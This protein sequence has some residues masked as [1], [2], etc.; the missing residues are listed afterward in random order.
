M[1]EFQEGNFI[2]LAND[3]D[4]SQ[5]QYFI[6]KRDANNKAVLASAAT[7]DIEGVLNNAPKAKWGADVAVI[8][9]NGTFKVVAG[10]NITKGDKLTSD[11]NGKAVTAA[12]TTAGAQPTKHVFGVALANAVANDVV[13]YRRVNLIY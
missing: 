10:G 7:D 5:K 1:S 11:A 9:G 6:V 3:A 8:N 2:A 12:Q 4:L 13:E